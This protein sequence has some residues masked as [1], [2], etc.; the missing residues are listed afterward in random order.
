MYDYSMLRG[1]IV[2]K[3]GSAQKFSDALGQ[4][5]VTISRKL[6]GLSE[7]SQSDIEKWSEFLE[8]N[9]NDYASFYFTQKV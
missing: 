3:Y 7:F 9:P 5:N 4:S 8:I 2:E 6:Q 1:R